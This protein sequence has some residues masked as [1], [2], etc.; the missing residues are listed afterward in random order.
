MPTLVWPG[1]QPPAQRP[2]CPATLMEI[3]APGQEPIPP[4]P[5]ALFLGDNLDVLAYLLDHGYRGRVKLIYLDPPFD[6]GL[7]HRRKVRLRLPK[8]PTMQTAADAIIG[9]QTQ[10]DDRWG[11]GAYLQFVYERLPLLRELLAEDGTIWLHC[12]HRQAHHLRVL[13]QECF[14]EE[15]YLNTVIW[16]SQVA[17][18]A[19]VKAAHLPASA[20]YLTIFAKDHQ[21]AQAWHPPKKQLVL[22][23]AEAAQTYLRDER[24]FFRTSDPGTYSFA[25][26]QALHAEGR[27][28]APYGGEIVIDQAAGRIYASHGGNIGVKYYLARQGRDRWVVERAIDN[29][30]EDIP[31]LGVTPGE[32]LGYPTQKTEALLQRIVGMATDPGDLVLDCFMGSGTTLAVAQQL[33]RRWIGCDNNGG[34]LITTRRRLQ[35]QALSASETGHAFAV[36]HMAG[37]MVAPAGLQVDLQIAR[38]PQNHATIGVTIVGVTSPG[39]ERLMARHA[40][41]PLVAPGEWRALIDCVAIDPAYDGQIFRSRVVDA[42]RKKSAQVQGCYTLTAP[43]TPTTVAVRITDLLGEEIVITATV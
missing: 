41:S 23:E 20:H 19:K 7:A 8:A 35:A 34:A 43:S 28:Y 25:R 1:K 30:W 31:G 10:Y 9:A 24:G 40:S 27:L 15:N 29:I 6:T 33:G 36:Y 14:G 32:D 16:R 13:L 38:N 12:D 4:P 37:P 2:P 39:L 42:P 3:F 18:G 26:L 22:R 17:R 11:E 5:N 21:S